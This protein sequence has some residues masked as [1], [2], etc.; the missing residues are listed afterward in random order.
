MTRASAPSQMR[1]GLPGPV[2]RSFASIAVT[3]TF[4]HIPAGLLYELGGFRIPYSV[5]LFPRYT[6]T[7]S[8]HPRPVNQY[9]AFVPE[10]SANF[11]PLIARIAITRIP[12]A[13]AHFPAPFRR[14][15][16]PWPALF[17]VPPA[18][19]TPARYPARRPPR[20]TPRRRTPRAA[21]RS[22]EHT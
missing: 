20:R 15:A 13:L 14:R 1:C 8:R 17:A 6:T 7:L 12:S 5:S 16:P 3:I 18:S 11:R 9:P 22:E 21:Y 2:T 19:R 10:F 4:A